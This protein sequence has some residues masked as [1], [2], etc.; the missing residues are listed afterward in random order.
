VVEQNATIE[1]MFS[2][3]K[4]VPREDIVFSGYRFVPREYHHEEEPVVG[5]AAIADSGSR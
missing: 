1:S 4:F 2:G 5:D 3:Y